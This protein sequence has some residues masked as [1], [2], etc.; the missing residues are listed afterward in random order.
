MV[1]GG[2]GGGGRGPAEGGRVQLAVVS[3]KAR[4]A[5][6]GYDL[7]YYFDTPTGVLLL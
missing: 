4:T 1:S 3:A 2:G 7:R 6:V 5:G